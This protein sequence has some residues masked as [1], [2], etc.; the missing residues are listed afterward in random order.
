MK[1]GKNLGKMARSLFLV[2]ALLSGVCGIIG[3]RHGMGISSL[4]LESEPS[5]A[6]GIAWTPN[7]TLI[8]N[9]TNTQTNVQVVSDGAGGAIIV[10]EDFRTGGTTNYDIYAQRIDAAGNALWTPNGT[11]ICNAT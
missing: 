5:T 8:C 1:W 7:G 4:A 2:T 10:W 3:T 9:A 11:I 6:M